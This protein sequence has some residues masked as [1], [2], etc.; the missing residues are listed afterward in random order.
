[1]GRSVVRRAGR[2][3]PGSGR[4]RT[5]RSDRRPGAVRRPRGERA[6]E[7]GR[8]VRPGAEP[9]PPLRPAPRPPTDSRVTRNTLVRFLGW[10][11][12]LLQ[13]DVLFV[14]RAAW[15]RRRLR[16]GPVRTL[17]AGCGTGALTMLAARAGNDALG[18]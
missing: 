15:V 18:L 7:G 1:R 9:G 11:A 4:G 6:G 12:L 17:D 5:R 10:P 8:P 14:E 2:T 13:G 16:R 3:D